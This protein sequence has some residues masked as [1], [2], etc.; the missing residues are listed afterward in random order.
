L[1]FQKTISEDLMKA[2]RSKKTFGKTGAHLKKKPE[3][4]TGKIAL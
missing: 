3:S 2:G 4:T 1:V